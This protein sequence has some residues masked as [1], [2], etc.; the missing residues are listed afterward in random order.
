MG[1]KDSGFR[2]H[3]HLGLG[4]F[5]LWVLGIRG[6][7]LRGHRLILGDLGAW[8]LG[9]T[10]SRLTRGVEGREILQPK[11]LFQQVLKPHTSLNAYINT[12]PLNLSPQALNRLGLLEVG[13][14]IG[15]VD[16]PLATSDGL[17]NRAPRWGTWFFFVRDFGLGLGV[18]DS[19]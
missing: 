17:R 15:K 6:L 10:G 4:G 14:E 9:S 11:G 8:G 5:F 2:G 18:E 19:G 3:V 7:G 1:F 12:E 16:P 13:F